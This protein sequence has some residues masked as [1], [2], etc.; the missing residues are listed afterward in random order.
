M[1]MTNPYVRYYLD[2]QQGYGMSVFRGSQWQMGHGQTGYGLGGLFR[3]FARAVARMVKR[4]VKSLGKIALNTG[5]DVTSFLDETSK[6][7]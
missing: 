7:R 1:K 2:Q 6:N 5:V 3:S 4:G